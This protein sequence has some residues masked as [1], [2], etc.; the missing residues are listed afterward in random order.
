MRG[1]FDRPGVRKG[2]KTWMRLKKTVLGYFTYVP[3]KRLQPS[4]PSSKPFPNEAT[5]W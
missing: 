3:H 5:C 2:K 4:K 1:S